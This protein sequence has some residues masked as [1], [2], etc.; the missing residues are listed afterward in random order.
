MKRCI[1]LQL[2]LALLCPTAAFTDQSLEQ[3][4]LTQIVRELEL[5]RALVDKAREQTPLDPEQRIR[6]KYTVLA[7]QLLS[8][9]T[10][11][12][13]HIDYQ[14]SQPRQYWSLDTPMPQGA[15]TP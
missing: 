10:A 4:R 2:V 11:V 3:E 1:A 7:D 5:V 8:L 15:G 9:E 14:N 12:R 6:F 13:R